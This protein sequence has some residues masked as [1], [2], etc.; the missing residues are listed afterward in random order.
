M[1]STLYKVIGGVVLIFLPNNPNPDDDDDDE[2]NDYDG[3]V[4]ILLPPHLA[5]FP[6]G[7][8]SLLTDWRT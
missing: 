3:V 5:D 8:L 6:R 4:L 2:V 7:I 1:F